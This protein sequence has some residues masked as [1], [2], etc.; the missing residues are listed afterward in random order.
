MR[1]FPLSPRTRV[2]LVV[3]VV[4]VGGWVGWWW[5]ASTLLQQ[6]LAASVETQRRAGGEVR[7]GEI[8]LDGFPWRLRATIDDIS[9]GLR[10]GSTWHGPGLV[11]DAPLWRINAL[12]LR[13]V[14]QQEIHLPP[15]VTPATVL[16]EGG[17]GEATLGGAAG[18]TQATLTLSGVSAPPLATAARI[19]LTAT[20]PARAVT[21]HTET[22]LTVTAAFT[23]L[24]VEKAESLPLGPA[25]TSLSIAARVMGA[26][27]HISL[28]ELSAWSRDGGTVELDGAA[29]RW[30][31]LALDAKGTLALDRDLQPEGALT[32]EI[33]GF[34]EAI[35]TLVAT[36]W[37]KP[38]N[39][40]TAK[41]IL[42]GLSPR[43]EGEAPPA[44][45]TARLPI[46]VHQHF[47]HI[48]PFRLAP[49]PLVV[50]Q[51]PAAG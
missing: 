26:P 39:A 19:E 13:L 36:G 48:G 46:S 9:V 7:L 31:P 41:A 32:A 20:L 4:M 21:E 45:P 44:N 27:P 42:T 2:G 6:T 29:L 5:L 17:D 23:T 25:I 35:D 28:A 15:G 18:I 33:S 51:V 22:G 47:V 40:Q 10:D 3:L 11:I 49:L 8:R 24:R 38:K 14:G 43:A 50:W 1:G 37:I 12:H 34:G 30:G 16:V